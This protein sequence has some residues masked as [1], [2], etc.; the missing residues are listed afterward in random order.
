MVPMGK[1]TYGQGWPP[2]SLASRK[3][4]AGNCKSEGSGTAKPGTDE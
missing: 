2:E 3:G 4:V 1:V